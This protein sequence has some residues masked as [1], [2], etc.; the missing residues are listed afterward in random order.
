M[1][2][3]FE[4]LLLP[5]LDQ[6]SR[7]RWGLFGQNEHL[8]PEARYWDWPEARQL[9]MLATDIQTLRAE[10]GERNSLCD[11]FLDL[12]RLKGANVPGEP[13][14]AAELLAEMEPE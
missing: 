10:V 7:G 11:N 8:D 2:A 3:E 13:K 4:T 14:L 9:K 5:C 12:C 6:C 1:E